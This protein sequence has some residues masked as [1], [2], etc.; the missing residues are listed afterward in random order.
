LS[1]LHQPGIGS[2]F[3]GIDDSAK[4]IVD[5]NSAGAHARS[6]RGGSPAPP[7]SFTATKLSYM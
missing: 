5:H 1:A 3:P 2:R 4:I 6:Q 7:P